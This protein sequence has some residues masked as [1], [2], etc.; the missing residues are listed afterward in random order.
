M[1]LKRFFYFFFFIL[2]FFII[3]TYFNRN[4]F[5]GLQKINFYENK[6][7]FF[8]NENL[9]NNINNSKI[10]IKTDLFNIV[11]NLLN[12]NIEKLSLCNYKEKLNSEKI[13]TILNNKKDN[14]YQAKTE[15]I[16]NYKNNIIKKKNIFFFTEKKFFELEKNN[17]FLFVPMYNISND[18]VIFTKTFI[19]KKNSYD[20]EIQYKINNFTNKKINFNF[21]NKLIKNINGSNNKYFFLNNLFSKEYNNLSYSS[22]NKKFVN[23]KLNDIHDNNISTSSGW[24]SILQQYFF[25]SWIPKI[26]EINDIYIKKNY[27]NYIEI[28]YIFKNFLINPYSFGVFSSKLFVGPKIYDKIYFL[29]PNLNLIIDYGFFSFISKPLFKLL[30]FFYFYTNNWGFSIISITLFIKILLYPITKSQYISMCKIKLLQPKINYIKKKFNNDKQKMSKKLMYLYKKNKINP[31]GG[32]LPILIQMPIFLS[33]YNMLN[34]SIELRHSPFIFWIKDLSEKDPFYFLPFLMGFT[35]WYLQKESINNIS[36]NFQ[37]I[38]MNIIPF[39]FSF[40]FIWFPSGLV[41]YYFISN[42]I[43]IFQQCWISYFFKKNI[44]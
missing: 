35:M 16:Q 2:F 26:N 4:F 36:D 25:S 28:G 39:I 3:I 41:L 38:I 22:D 19:F 32:C 33:L 37:K 15:I 11:I 42:M 9:L 8:K 17:F 21:Y 44:N 18:G 43:T 1:I 34:N 24:I 27:D 5:N 29:A 20:I 23:L 40:F 7:Y 13:L 30:N 12:G 14:I 31:L 6:N 10:F